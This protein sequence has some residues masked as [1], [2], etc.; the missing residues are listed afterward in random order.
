MK[1]AAVGVERQSSDGSMQSG[2]REGEG[3]CYVHGATRV[4]RLSRAGC[5][6][7]AKQQSSSKVRRAAA[8]ESVR[9][10]ALRG[11]GVSNVDVEDARGVQRCSRA[12]GFWLRG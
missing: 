7:A 6:S 11:C 10:R 4:L 1:R 5:G 2:P 8:A 9:R 12:E 3:E